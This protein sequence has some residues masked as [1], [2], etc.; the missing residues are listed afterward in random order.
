[1][2]RIGREIQCLPYAGFF[3]DWEEKG[4][5]LT[6]WMSNGGVCRTAQA[7]P[8]LSI[9][10]ENIFWMVCSCSGGLSKAKLC[11]I[12]YEDP[13][14]QKKNICLV[15][16]DTHNWNVVENKPPF[17]FNLVV[18]S[19][20]V[21]KQETDFLPKHNETHPT[22]KAGSPNPPTIN[23]YNHFYQYFQ[24]SD[25]TILARA[26]PN[27]KTTYAERQLSFVE[28]ESFHNGMQ[29]PL[30]DLVAFAKPAPCAKNWNN[31]LILS[32]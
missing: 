17:F 8:G 2:I 5:S 29:H 27:R 15:N 16:N 10:F 4:D 30:R 19:T 22:S 14:K 13:F 20:K 21:L 11:A 3:E 9:I 23:V 31:S 18:I 28:Q 24:R 7:T 6:E 12:F 1:M 25:Q 26:R 32:V